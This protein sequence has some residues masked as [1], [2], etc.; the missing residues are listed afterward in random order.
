M[1][2]KMFKGRG[3]IF[4]ST[5]FLTKME[6][7]GIFC[8]AL[9]IVLICLSSCASYELQYRDAEYTY[10]SKSAGQDEIPEHIIYLIGDAGNHPAGAPILDHLRSLFDQSSAAS[11]VIWLGDNIYEVGLAPEGHPDHEDGKNKILSQVHTLDNYPGNIFFIPGNHDWYEY[12]QEGIEREE[13]LIEQAL[14]TRAISPRQEPESYFVPSSGCPDPYVR[15]INEELALIFVDSHWH[16]KSRFNTE[17]ETSR[18][19]VKSRTEYLKALSDVFHA[20]RDK[21]IL[22]AA[23]HPLLTYG[24]HGG[25]FNLK[26]YLFPMTQVVDQLYIPAPFA[27][28][29]FNKSRPY[30][31]AQDYQHPN[32]RQYRKEMMSLAREHGRTLFAGGHEHTLQYIE[33]DRVPI[34]VSGGGSKRSE[35]GL[36]PGSEFAVG[37]LGYATIRIFPDNRVLLEY[38]AEAEVGGSRFIP[39]FHKWLFE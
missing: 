35:S 4:E 7:T 37:H 15:E 10:T 11:T 2:L 31:T 18:C 12:G 14:S 20:H 21:T 1:I 36:G 6:N 5:F 23:H 27:G 24:M 34:I 39:V 26:H 3:N 16:L 28:Y 9:I 22:V 32:Y 25:Y 8:A 38:F 33:K 13:N 17:T 19:Q 29:F 30:L